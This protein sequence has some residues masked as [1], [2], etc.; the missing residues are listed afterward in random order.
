MTEKWTLRMLR[1]V[2]ERGGGCRW[3]QSAEERENCIYGMGI[4]GLNDQLRSKAR[5]T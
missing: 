2:S 4:G 3:N 5:I 1:R